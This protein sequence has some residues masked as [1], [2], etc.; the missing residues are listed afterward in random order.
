M[1]SFKA[2]GGK[3]RF[4]S[5]LPTSVLGRDICTLVMIRIRQRAFARTDR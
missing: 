5:P 1:H 2:G 3:V 4:A